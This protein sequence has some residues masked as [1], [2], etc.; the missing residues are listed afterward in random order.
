MIFCSKRGLGN[1]Y[2]ETVS[3]DAKIDEARNPDAHSF[4]CGTRRVA[5]HA[6]VFRLRPSL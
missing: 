2:E 3:L 6:G 5:R 4:A 1:Y